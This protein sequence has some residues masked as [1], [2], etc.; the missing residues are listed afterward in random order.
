F[1]WKKTIQKII[2]WCRCEVFQAMLDGHYKESKEKKVLIPDVKKPVFES[3]LQYLYSDHAEFE[4]KHALD[5]L[6]LS[7]RFRVSRLLS[8]CEYRMSKVVEKACTEKIE[9]SNFDVIGLLLLA[10]KHNARQLSDFCLHFISTNYAPLRKR[11]E[12]ELLQGDNKK[13]VEEHRWPPKWYEDKCVEYE[14][15]LQTWNKKYGTDKESSGC[16]IM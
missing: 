6:M 2:P 8:W 1:F 5:L 10:Q 12:F 13:Y 4:D 7:N 14:K 9:K 3:F 15:E 16:L 11:K